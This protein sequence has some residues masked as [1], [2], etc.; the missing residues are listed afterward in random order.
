MI[1]NNYDIIVVGCGLSGVVI[2]ERFSLLQ[3]KKV[4]IID[5]RDHIGGN[6]YDYHDEETNILMNKYGAH[7]FHTNHEEVFEYINQYGN[8]SPWEHKVLG[9]IDDKHLPIPANITTVNEIFNLDIKSKEE[10]DEWLSENQ[11]KYENITNGEEMAKSRVGEVLYEKIFKHYTYKQWKKY[12]NELAPEVLA[13]IPVRNSFDDRYFS[14][15]YQVLPE[16]GYTAFFQSILDKHKHNI[17][18]KLN[19]DFFDIKDQ[20]SKDHIVI[21]TGPIDA[22]FA[23]KGLPTLEYRSIDFHIERQM[24]TE[25]YQPYS[26]VNYPSAETPYTRCVEYKHFLNQESDHTVYVKETTTDVG[27]PYYPVLNDRNKELYEKYQKMAEEEGE[28]IHFLGRLA[29]YK[30]F[31]MDQAIKNSLDYY[32]EHF[33]NKGKKIF[34][35]FSGRERYMRILS[36]YIDKLLDQ[37]IID[38]V[39]IWDFIKNDND[40]EYINN[41]C[42]KDKYFLK[43][44]DNSTGGPWDGYYK[45]YYENLNDE[46]ILIKC[47]DDIV[48]IDVETFEEYLSSVKNGMFYYP[49]IVNNDITAYYQQ[50]YNIHNL[51]DYDVDFKKWS[52]ELQLIKNYPVP[53]SGGW[54]WLDGDRQP[55]WFQTFEKADQIHKL[56]LTNPNLFKLKNKPLER[57]DSRISINM[58][59]CTGVTAKK[60]FMKVIDRN[61]DDEAIISGTSRAGNIINL[62]CSVVHFQFG[63]QN[64]KILDELYLDK[65]YKL[66]MSDSNTNELP[67]NIFLLWF[68]GWDNAPWLQRQVRK[69]WETNNPDWNIILLDESN[70]R[71]YI[72]DVDYIYDKSKNI[73]YQAKSDIIRLSLLKNIGGVWADATMLCMQPLDNWVNEQVEPAGMWMYHGRGGGMPKE[74][75][76]AIWFIVSKKDN[77]IVSEWKKECDNYWNG[78]N[79]DI[80]Y[81]WLDVWFKKLYYSN[82][83][84]KELWSK[85]PYLYCEDKGSA[86]T[87][88]PY[89][90]SGMEKIDKE[91]QKMFTD[92]PPY[93]LKLWDHFNNIFSEEYCTK[94]NGYY[95]I[96]L[97]INRNLVLNNVDPVIKIFCDKRKT[98]WFKYVN[99]CQYFIENKI[100]STIFRSCDTNTHIIYNENGKQKI[101]SG[102]DY[103]GADL[104]SKPC[105]DLEQAKVLDIDTN[106]TD[107][108]FYIRG[109]IR[110]S[111]KTTRL[112]CFIKLLKLYFPNIKFILQTW[113]HQECKK[114]ESWRNIHQNNTIISKQT[115][116]NYFEDKDVTEQCLIIDEESIELIG[117]TDGKIG[118]G[119]CPKRGWK[120]MWYGIYKG[121]EH[122]NSNSSNNMVVSFRYDYFDIDESEKI[123]EGEIIRF[124]KNNLANENIQFLKHNVVGTDNLYMGKY[125]KIKSLIDR[126]HF[127]L[128]DILDINKKICHQEFLVNIISDAM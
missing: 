115:L 7:L 91:L 3:N 88:A 85:V 78:N 64:G 6:C 15:K 104:S 112:K 97:A 94:S 1:L 107:F 14:D 32:E 99:N 43:I 77:Y 50:K 92:S 48:Y 29:S 113:K 20:L 49:N 47:D 65:Y 71:Y 25:S 111:F 38:E 96:Q 11:V 76:P 5:K 42:K 73:S 68:Q 36:I 17:D 90:G 56:F 109:H 63:P 13:R 58:F 21:Y 110:N 69:S 16:K 100:E 46:D 102:Y 108:Y 86:H 59:A 27:E 74:I 126:F 12:P 28:N 9:L 62:N 30:Y 22:Y 44:P 61:G 60:H 80:R 35:V 66:S 18:V 54:E 45:Y 33:K 37:N 89:N 4:L 118:I 26:V 2:A 123:N 119:P 83:N 87:L 122:L 103:V 79:H 116:E 81:Y 67:K 23:D 53:I 120:N 72:N 101:L 127:N 128:D 124:I 57:Y 114:G 121:L 75:G 40:R 70:L 34:S 31:N 8:W 52:E 95:A 125:D 55:G 24:N 106:E 117:T 105:N 84:F 41:L 51:F 39:H 82:S 10:M 93:A 19:C 98:V